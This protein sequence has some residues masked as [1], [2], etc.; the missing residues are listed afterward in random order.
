[1]KERIS[2]L[3]LKRYLN[4]K[5]QLP[6]YNPNADFQWI[7]YYSALPWLKLDIKIPHEE[8]LEE[9]QKLQS[10]LSVHRD[11][12]GESQGWKGACIHGRAFSET[13][14]DSYYSEPKPHTW[15][16]EALEHLP[17][18]VEYFR[19][20]WPADSFNRLRIMLLEPNGY[21]TFHKDHDQSQLTAINIA[22]TQPKDCRF[23][24]EYHGCVPFEPG[25]AYWLDISNNH[26][27]FNDSQQLRW[28]I[29]V[30]QDLNH[31]K[32]QELVV[33][34]YHGLYNV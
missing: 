29:I 33:K 7:R 30:H 18:T 6:A 22:I 10:L 28:H 8:I 17:N 31:P 16:P 1:M 14:E 4:H 23:V 26:T 19:D 20:E 12:Y 34:S 9:I 32:F 13:R 21:I 5:A 15:T 2:R 3:I 11:D 27:V 25:S 24:M